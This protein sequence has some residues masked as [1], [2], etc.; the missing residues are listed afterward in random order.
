MR[1]SG[2]QTELSVVKK[3]VLVE[4]VSFPF[5][6]NHLIRMLK[7]SAKVPTG[8]AS[9]FFK[10][11]AEGSGT[12]KLFEKVKK[13]LEAAEKDWQE[14]FANML[15]S[16]SEE[17]FLPKTLFLTADDDCVGLFKHAITSG[18]FSSF[19]V[20]PTSFSVAEVGNEMLAPLVSWAPSQNQ[21]PFVSLIAAF[22]NELRR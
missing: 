8:G 20:S 3:G 13:V 15:S 21:D 1:L 2:E 14:K 22:A 18:E 10:L 6:K 4:T 12:G 19:T 9:A 11:Y 16:F 5:G 7:E 17:M